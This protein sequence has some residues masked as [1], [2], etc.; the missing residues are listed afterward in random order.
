MSGGSG[1]FSN[2]AKI[3]G[4]PTAGVL[5]TGAALGYLWAFGPYGWTKSEP[6]CPA[7][8]TCVVVAGLFKD[9]TY[10]FGAGG[11][12]FGVDLNDDMT[13]RLVSRLSLASGN[14]NLTVIK[15][16]REVE[17]PEAGD[18]NEGELLRESVLHARAIA[19]HSKANLVVIGRVVGDDVIIR[20]IDPLGNDVPRQADYSMTSDDS[21]DHLSTAL[22]T[23]LANANHPVPPAPPRPVQPRP[24]PAVVASNTAP[25]QTQLAATTP[26]AP[27]PTPRTVAPL[28]PQTIA[29]TQ[30][31]PVSRTTTTTAAA[32]P[33]QQHVTPTPP[34]QRTVR[35]TPVVTPPAQQ[36]TPPV[37]RPATTPAVT[38][39]NL[40]SGAMVY[41]CTDDR[42][43]RVVYD[44]EARVAT[45]RLYGRPDLRLE[46]TPAPARSF[47]FTRG[48]NT[49]LTGSGNQVSW[50][51]AGASPVTCLRIG[52]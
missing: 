20:F 23:A 5:I 52:Y 6:V 11:Q 12:L 19:D 34:P 13:E 47:R 25:A 18:P 7:D 43:I 1:I 44:A 27:A 24:R 16:T 30:I 3:A 37:A 26:A 21:Q 22:R 9:V 31:T 8:T 38:P 2:L 39:T 45:V 49:E 36:Q 48:S 35:P 32:P 29:T 42:V 50:R 28:P 14:E 10:G 33:Q 51:Y 17:V 4:L 15:Y 41:R 46:A 40:P